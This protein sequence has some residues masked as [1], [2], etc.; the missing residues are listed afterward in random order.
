MGCLSKRK[1]REPTIQ[2][3]AA[4]VS[5]QESLEGDRTIPRCFGN[6]PCP[7]KLA[8]DNQSYLLEQAQRIFDSALKPEKTQEI[9]ESLAQVLNDSQGI[10][11]QLVAAA[12]RD[13]TGL[14]I[15]TSRRDGEVLRA[16]GMHITNNPG[17]SYSIPVGYEA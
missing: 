11:S 8:L 10:P 7:A 1:A 6:L 13:N 3:K 15:Q 9:V 16:S 5:L 14:H 17:F 2:L 12:I 4:E